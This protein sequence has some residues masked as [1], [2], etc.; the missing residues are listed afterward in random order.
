MEQL[1]DT[2][3][4]VR[5]TDELAAA[6][7]VNNG[8][9]LVYLG[10]NITIG[11]RITVNRAKTAVT[12]DGF[13]P[14]NET[15]VRYTLSDAGT[16]PGQIY[17]ETLTDLDITFQNML[18]MG[19][20]YFGIL[21]VFDNDQTGRVNATF[22][23][24]TYIGPQ[25]VWHTWGKTSI[26]DC[27][28]TIQAAASRAEEVA[29]ANMLEVGGKT[30]IQHN[31]TNRAV[32]NLYR[33]N[34]YF[35]LLDGAELEVIST[36]T[37][38]NRGYAIPFTVGKNAK[39]IL[40]TARS[41]SYSTSETLSNFLVDKGAVF[42]YIRTS[43]SGADHAVYVSGNFTVNQGANVYM[44]ADYSQD[45]A[46][47]RFTAADAGLYLNSPRSFVL[48]KSGTG[49]L[50]TALSFY[51]STNFEMNGGQ[52]NCWAAATPFPAA[53]TF[54]DV[55]PG[56]WYKPDWSSFMLKGTVTDAATNISSR[57]ITDKELESL[58]PLSLMNLRTARVLSVGELPLEIGPIVDD[59]RPI[60]GTSAPL[61]KIR[62][63]HDPEGAGNLYNSVA[64]AQGRYT[65]SP[66]QPL[67]IDDDVQVSANTPFLITTKEREV[68]GIGEIGFRYVPD[69]IS[70]QPTPVK[71]IPDV[72]L[73][74][75]TLSSGEQ[76]PIIIYDTRVDNRTPWE[77]WAR[78]TG[79]CQAEGGKYKLLNAVVFAFEN[80]ETITL[81][82][83][84]AKVY[85][86][87][88]TPYG[89]PNTT[90]VW[91]EDQGILARIIGKRR[92]DRYT[93][94]IIWELRTED[95][96]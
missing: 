53:G 47:I 87:E 59:G 4:V 1:N 91:P 64:D 75:K 92:C 69:V 28:I 88:A 40:T 48:Y 26:Y 62:V 24:L 60:S 16:D 70:F 43:N 11:N 61:A 31:S 34:G 27:D 7:S 44:Q 36:H 51:G 38:L 65:I 66:T 50:A 77:L 13:Y 42:H 45:G 89:T 6:L 58:P 86:T 72:L 95:P 81:T 94:N 14:P 17:V 18:I 68:V 76:D 85:Q 35:K 67:V 54:E 15:G 3:V 33:D 39:F 74:R 71:K 56:R 96:I 9:T 49:T 80:G 57:T 25:L 93:T 21:R 23:N 2:T 55:A 30:K 46:L 41:F 12:I 82:R 84:A 63:L 90:L 79:D 78:I 29:E 22:R 73:K 5:S 10:A 52:V 83:D 19:K 8:Y 32:F 37:F 20:N